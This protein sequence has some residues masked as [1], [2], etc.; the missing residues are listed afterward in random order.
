MKIHSN[1]ICTYKRYK[2]NWDY[3]KE[4]NTR[5]YIWK[6]FRFDTIKDFVFMFYT[7]IL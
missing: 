5:L 1:I 2:L 4:N 7:F 3:E 6:K